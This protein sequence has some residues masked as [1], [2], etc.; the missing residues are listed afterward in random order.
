MNPLELVLFDVN[1][2]VFS[3]DRLARRLADE[4]LADG[5]LT[6]WFTRILRDGFALTAVDDSPAFKELA[7]AHLRTLL[8]E[9]EQDPDRAESILSTFSELE[10]HADVAPA[11]A[12]LAEAGVRIVTLTNGHAEMTETLLQRNELDGYVERALSVDEA[13]I[14]KPRA[15][16]Y[17]WA[18]E[19]CGAELGTTAMVA[20]HSWDVDGAKRA[21]LRTG[22][23]TRLEGGFIRLFTA[24]DVVG[25]DLVAV[26][27]GLLAM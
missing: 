24:P 22:Y 5:S 19:R 21:G 25:D 13:G 23:C 8:R 1:E 16:A 3:L 17:T 10:A 11:F 9:A 26:V 14:W 6:L 27:D 2:T 18:V 7:L 12:R 4:G 20:V 15:E